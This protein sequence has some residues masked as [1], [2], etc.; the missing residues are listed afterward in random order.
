MQEEDI[1]I[2][3]KGYKFLHRFRKIL[4]GELVMQRNRQDLYS[5]DVNHDVYMDKYPDLTPESLGEHYLTI[6][7]NI[8]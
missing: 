6:G 7:V 4:S 3:G 2:Q 5:I 1:L 8:T